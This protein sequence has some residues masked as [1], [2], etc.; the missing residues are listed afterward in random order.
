[1]KLETRSD[2]RIRRHRRLRQKI[3]GTAERP[4]MCVYISN[5]HIEVQF[6]NDDTGQTLASATTRGK[7][8]VNLN[9]ATATALGSKAAEAAKAKDITLVV[10]DRGGYKYHGRVKALVEAALAAGLKVNDEPQEE[11][12]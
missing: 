11:V 4:R 1:M 2:Y 8:D 7:T 6:V 5:K 12:K 10:V 9:V 3:Q